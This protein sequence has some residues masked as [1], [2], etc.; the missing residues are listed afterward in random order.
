MVQGPVEPSSAI[1]PL[2]IEEPVPYLEEEPLAVWT[3]TEFVD[4]GDGIPVVV[5]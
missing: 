3:G 1:R 2:H 5:F 4:P